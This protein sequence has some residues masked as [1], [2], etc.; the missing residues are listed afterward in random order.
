M[1]GRAARDFVSSSGRKQMVTE[2]TRIDGGVLD[3]II[4][5]QYLVDITS[6]RNTPINQN[7]PRTTIPSKL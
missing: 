3:V 6:K 7:G 4:I 5:Q 2:P 1:L